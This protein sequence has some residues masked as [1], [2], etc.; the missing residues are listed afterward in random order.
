MQYDKRFFTTL[1]GI[2]VVVLIVSVAGCTSSP[3][4]SPTPTAAPSVATVAPTVTKQVQAS[5]TPTPTATPTSTP[6]PTSKPQPSTSP[7][8]SSLSYT[9]PFVG[10]KNSNVYHVPWCYEAQKIKPQNLVTFPNAK[11]AQ[12]AGYRP[13]E[14]CKPETTV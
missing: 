5:S 6:A 7:T 4:A 14:V 2:F 10:S 11:A 3:S 12:A 8:P 9:G 1:A 13:C